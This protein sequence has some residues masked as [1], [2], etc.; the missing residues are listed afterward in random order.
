M[1]TVIAVESL[2]KRF[3]QTLAVDDLSFE[4]SR[5]SIVGFLG[6][7][8]A[9][10]TTTLRM[11]L[12]LTMPTLGRA[13]VEGKLFAELPDPVSVVGAVLDSALFHPDRT[14]RDHLRVFAKAA[15]VPPSRV[16]DLLRLVELDHAGDRR[17]KGYSL[18]MRQRLSLATALLGDPRI[19]ILDEPANGLDP[20][21]IRWL[22]DFLRARSAEGRTVLVSSHVLSEV[23]QM[24]DHVVVV[25]RGRLATQGRL[26]EL[27]RT[28]GTPVRVRSNDPQLLAR[29]LVSRGITV[30]DDGAG[31]LVAHHTTPEEIGDT[32]VTQQ[33]A[34]YEMTTQPHTLEDVFLQSTATAEAA[35][36]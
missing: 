1:E 36:P 18:G 13:T 25:N 24:V 4:V 33:I 10:K 34:I 8:G 11:L 6:P 21:G 7:N 20:Q 22:R 3:G 28:T 12:G 17:V 14:G 19:L 27:T 9:G 30:N 31:W 23:A 16:D 5:G 15:D 26:D 2:T 32:A 29:V 35:L